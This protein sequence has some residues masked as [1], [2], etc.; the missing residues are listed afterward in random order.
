MCAFRCRCAADLRL[1]ACR[2]VRCWS[3]RRR[4][5]HCIVT[6]PLEMAFPLAGLQLVPLAHVGLCKTSCLFEQQGRAALAGETA[7]RLMAEESPW[8]LHPANE[9]V[10]AGLCADVLG[11][12]HDAFAAVS[13]NKTDRSHW[14]KWVEVTARLGTPVWR[15]G[16][17]API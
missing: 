11:L 13:T 4:C 6:R 16:M 7:E 9:S 15:T 10:L 8:A 1:R 12:A 2:H 5:A 17:S 14:N 3:R